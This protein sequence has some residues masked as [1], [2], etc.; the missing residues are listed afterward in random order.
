M[1]PESTFQNRVLKVLLMQELEIIFFCS[2][3]STIDHAISN[4]LPEILARVMFQNSIQE[5]NIFQSEFM[6]SYAYETDIIFRETI[7]LLQK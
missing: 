2:S 5:G 6:M 3:Q 1:K 4:E 7:F